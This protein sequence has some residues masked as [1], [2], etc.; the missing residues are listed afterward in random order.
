[1]SIPATDVTRALF[2]P[3]HLAR[4]AAI[5]AL[6]FGYAFWMMWGAGEEIIAKGFLLLI[7]GTPVYV[8]LKWRQHR[9][10]PAE[11]LPPIAPITVAQPVREP[12]GAGR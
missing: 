5:A 1:M 6:A 3:K 12:V 2:N 8:F 11:V 9:S 4:D 10:A 7:A